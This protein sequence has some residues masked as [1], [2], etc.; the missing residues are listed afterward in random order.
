VTITP[1]TNVLVRALVRDEKAQARLAVKLLS[2]A[3]RIAISSACLCELGWVLRSVY[4]FSRS[5]IADAIHHLLEAENI[6]SNRAAAEVGLSLLRSGGDFSDGVLAYE[7]QSLGGEL[8]VSFDNKAVSLLR[9]LG[10]KAE[11]LSRL[12]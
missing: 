5:E 12:S 9:K 2:G 3:G 11:V 8:F 7:G 1:D 6:V 4:S 10:H